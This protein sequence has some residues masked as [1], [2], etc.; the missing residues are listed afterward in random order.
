MWAIPLKDKTS[1]GVARAEKLHTD[2]GTE[3]E[4]ML[5]EICSIRQIKMVHGAPYRPNVQGGDERW[6]ETL[7][8][9]LD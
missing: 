6:N 3:F 8:L 7:K 9:Q 5:K 1:E 2:N 4:G